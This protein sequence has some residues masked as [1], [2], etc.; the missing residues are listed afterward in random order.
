MLLACLLGL[1]TWLTL[2]GRGLGLASAYSPGLDRE[3]LQPDFSLNMTPM[4]STAMHNMIW[5]MGWNRRSREQAAALMDLHSGAMLGS[6]RR[7][8]PLGQLPDRRRA[9]LLYN[10]PRPSGML[11]LALNSIRETP[12]VAQRLIEVTIATGQMR[13]II[14]WNIP[15]TDLVISPQG[16]YLYFRSGSQT[17]FVDLESGALLPGP[18]PNVLYCEWWSDHELM[19]Y[20]PDGDSRRVIDV[21]DGSIR[22][23]ISL[24]DL[25]MM[26]WSYGLDPPAVGHFRV[27]TL[28]QDEASAYLIV[29]QTPELLQ[30]DRPFD[31]LEDYNAMLQRAYNLGEPGEEFRGRRRQE[32]RPVPV[33]KVVPIEKASFLPNGAITPLQQFP[34]QKLSSDSRFSIQMIET[35]EMHLDVRLTD[36]ATS[37]TRMVARNQD[38]GEPS[39]AFFVGNLLIYFER[40]AYWLLDPETGR[41]ARIFPPEH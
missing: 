34:Y 23:L 20:D 25:D 6:A 9:I 2:P 31:W 8:I 16:Q 4:G 14:Q 29:D 40:P 39:L 1:G 41:R 36:R 7:M 26:L 24:N 10:E 21:H 13:E 22:T 15:C 5:V 3:L 12:K 38:R 19:F 32:M 27:T 30:R 28:V 37:T 18:Q 35:S 11:D 33:F 17:G